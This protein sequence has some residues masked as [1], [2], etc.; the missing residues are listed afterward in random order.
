MASSPLAGQ[1]LP[2]GRPGVQVHPQAADGDLPG[3]EG[4]RGREA[5]ESANHVRP[6]GGGAD[7][8]LR[9]EFLGRPPVQRGCEH[10][11]GAPDHAQGGMV[12]V[13]GRVQPRIAGGAQVAGADSEVGDPAALGDPP[14]GAGGRGAVEAV[15]GA[16]TEQ[17]AH[18]EVP[19]E[20]GEL[21]DRRIAGRTSRRCPDQGGLVVIHD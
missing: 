17:A 2:F 3:P 14:E 10:G 13:R 4:H 19:H 6:A 11:S 7:Q 18:A 5:G 15:D 9:A 8:D 20:T 21:G 16:S 12:E 1:L